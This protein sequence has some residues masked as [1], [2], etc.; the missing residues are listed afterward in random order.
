MDILEL[1][2]KMGISVT[3]VI[4]MP[5]NFARETVTKFNLQTIRRTLQIVSAAEY[6]NADRAFPENLDVPQFSRY[7]SPVPKV[8]LKL[9]VKEGNNSNQ[10]TITDSTDLKPTGDGN[11][12]GYIYNSL[13]GLIN[14]NHAGTDISNEEYNKY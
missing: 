6:A 3:D 13:E 11:V 2:K 1:F 4:L 9:S 10:V 8:M 7:L 12:G 14:I 5:I